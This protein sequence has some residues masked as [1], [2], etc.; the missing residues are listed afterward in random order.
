MEGFIKYCIV[1]CSTN[2]WIF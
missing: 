1:S 2:T